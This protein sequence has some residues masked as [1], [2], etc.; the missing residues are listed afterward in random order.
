MAWHG[1]SALC[2][3]AGRLGLASPWSSHTRVLV[4]L[5][6]RNSFHRAGFISPDARGWADWTGRQTRVIGGAEQIRY[7]AARVG[8]YGWRDDMTCLRSAT[9]GR[10]M[11]WSGVVRIETWGMCPPYRIKCT[12]VSLPPRQPARCV[13]VGQS[14]G[15][16]AGRGIP[17]LRPSSYLSR[18]RPTVLI[19]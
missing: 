1:M 2:S 7:A 13:A 4:D 16:L 14:A 8:E 9:G 15:W 19:R 12:S 6:A 5:S 11:H 10:S 18:P 3:C 17:G